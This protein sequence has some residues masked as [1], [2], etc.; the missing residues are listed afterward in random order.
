MDVGGVMRCRSLST[1]IPGHRSLSTRIPGRAS[2]RRVVAESRDL[3]LVR[4]D[5]KFAA[6][7]KGPGSSQFRFSFIARP[8][9][10]VFL[11]ARYFSGS[12]PNSISTSLNKSSHVGLDFSMSSI[13]QSLRQRF[14]SRSRLTA[15][16][17]LS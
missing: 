10:R 6:T 12:K 1:R 4:I 14:K 17:A 9:M 11:M 3:Y 5:W 15:E 2:A 16:P 8:G 7:G 13:F